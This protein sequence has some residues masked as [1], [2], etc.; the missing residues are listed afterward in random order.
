MRKLE[1]ANSKQRRFGYT[2]SLKY[3]LV[4]MLS[5]RIDVVEASIRSLYTYLLSLPGKKR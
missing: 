3:H 4:V 2:R 1:A 5:A